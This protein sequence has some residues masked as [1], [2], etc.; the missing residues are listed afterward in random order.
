MTAASINNDAADDDGNGESE[1]VGTTN[2]LDNPV[3]CPSLT[4]SNGDSAQD[5]SQ[6]R[7]KNERDESEPTA[8]DF[9]GNL[10]IPPRSQTRSP[11]LSL[12]ASR[13]SLLVRAR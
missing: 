5:P 9:V 11:E 7:D 3:D 12:L 4:S 10:P 2:G 8:A 1:P 6:D 13:P